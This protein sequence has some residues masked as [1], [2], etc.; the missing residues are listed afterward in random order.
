M[1]RK[2]TSLINFIIVL[3]T[4]SDEELRLI[5]ADPNG[6]SILSIYR[7]SKSLFDV[8]KTKPY[9]SPYIFIY[10]FIIDSC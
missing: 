10:C 5:E 3:V 1:N 4:L 6:E 2:K 7:S 9:F 8:N